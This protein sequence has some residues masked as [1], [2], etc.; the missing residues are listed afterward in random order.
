M[1]TGLAQGILVS[2]LGAGLAML[3][4][5]AIG[6]VQLARFRRGDRTDGGPLE[7]GVLAV[8]G[9]VQPTADGQTVRSPVT[10]RPAVVYEYS[11]QR[12]VG[13]PATPDWR[14]VGGGQN[15][16][17]FRLETDD[18][19]ALVE[20]QGAG[21]ELPVA[22]EVE[23][24]AD[25]DE[26]DPGDPPVDALVVDDATDRVYVGDFG[27]ETGEIYRVVERRIEPDDELA[28]AGV[29]SAVDA[30]S[31]SGDRPADD[32]VVAFRSRGGS[33]RRAVGMPYAIGDAEGG[34]A[35]RLRNRA[36]TGLLFGLPLVMLSGVYLLAPPA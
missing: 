6:L 15:S 5:G 27:L 18:G 36:L 9:Q 21:L 26:I 7:P 10:A 22:D 29:A 12:K 4:Y 16:V 20:P 28:V 8:R 1:A 3:T 25:P 17:P 30:E 11:I 33:L 31:E 32:P 13:G 35:T 2:I 24:V 14:S 34:A 23:F 19:L